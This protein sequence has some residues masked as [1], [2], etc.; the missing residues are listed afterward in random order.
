MRSSLIVLAFIAATES[1]FSQSFL[2][3]YKGEAFH[4]SVYH[5][6]AQNIPGRVLCAYYDLSGESVAYHDTDHKNHG[7]GE[8]NPATGERVD[9]VYRRAK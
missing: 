7:S 9:A 2:T 8:L 1:A 6:G 3:Q 4:D 5:D